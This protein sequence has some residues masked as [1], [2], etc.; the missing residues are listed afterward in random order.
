LDGKLFIDY[1]TRLKRDMLL[2]KLEKERKEAG[3][4]L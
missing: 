4:V 2:K 1:L 3:T